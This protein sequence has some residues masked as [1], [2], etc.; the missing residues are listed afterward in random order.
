MILTVPLKKIYGKNPSAVAEMLRQGGIDTSR[1]YT[2]RLS[3]T[4]VRIE[5]VRMRGSSF[6]G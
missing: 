1:A 3:S 5:Q 6:A 4:G 2:Y